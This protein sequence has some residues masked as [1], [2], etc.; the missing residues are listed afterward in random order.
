M[1][2]ILEIL[3][4][5]KK[6]N[7]KQS[8]YI[9]Q[10]MLQDKLSKEQITAILISMKIRGEYYEEIA[11]AV[12][13][14][15]NK[16]KY[17]PKPDYPFADIVGT[18]GDCKNTINISTVS[19][20]V[21]AGCG[22]KIAKHNNKG[23]SS[24]S[25][26]SDILKKFGIDLYIS[27]EQSRKSLDELGICFLFAPK[28]HSF[29]NKKII[30]VRK[31]LKT[32]TLFNILGPLI[33]PAKPPLILIGVYN[34]KISFPIAQTLKLLKYQKALIVHSGGMDEITLHDDIQVVELKNEEIIS[35]SLTANDFGLEPQSSKYLFVNSS[36]ENYHTVSN[37]LKGKGNFAQ[38]SVVAANVAL[39][40]KLFG[41]EN[42]K[43]NTCL[44][45]NEIQSGKPY[46]RM[47][48]LVK[49]GQHE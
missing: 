29:F 35:Y 15:L 8:K 39:L 38:S 41:H 32:S 19:A 3:Y 17:F 7:Y 37:I 26:S 10:L 11:G 48:S 20:F 36:E 30:E 42:L 2:K 40:L 21:A 33:N 14:I 5:G 27:A 47:M 16:V 6:I 46:T 34:P 12:S 24:I 4:K 22:A 18:G 9:F 49:R 45:L 43:Q 1:Q 28:Y 25:G 44:A 23:I 31:I 13:S